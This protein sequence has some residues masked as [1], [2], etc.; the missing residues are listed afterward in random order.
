MLCG[1]SLIYWAEDAAVG[2]ESKK[3]LDILSGFSNLFLS[4]FTS[5]NKDFFHEVV[6]SHV[7][8]HDMET[9]SNINYPRKI[10]PQ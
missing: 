1:L 7:I 8:K 4:F 9:N 6:M 5:K 3:K 10:P 2:G